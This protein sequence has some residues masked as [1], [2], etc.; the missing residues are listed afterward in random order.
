MGVSDTVK[1]S[2][3]HT[4]VLNAFLNDKLFETLEQVHQ[5]Y[6]GHCDATKDKLKTGVP[7]ESPCKSRDQTVCPDPLEIFF[8][9]ECVGTLTFSFSHIMYSPILYS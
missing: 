8:Q 9:N 3:L 6:D 7:S 4:G 5:V 1:A 2:D